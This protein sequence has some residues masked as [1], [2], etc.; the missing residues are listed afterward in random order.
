MFFYILLYNIF[1]IFF[2][3]WNCRNGCIYI[4]IYIHTHQVGFVHVLES[5][6]QKAL[7]WLQPF[8]QGSSHFLHIKKKKVQCDSKSHTLKK[9][10]QTETHNERAHKEE[11][12]C[13]RWG[14]TTVIEGVETTV[15]KELWKLTKQK[16]TALTEKMDYLQ[17]VL[18][19][20]QA[21]NIIWHPK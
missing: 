10:V 16:W 17:Q 12:H 18:W 4:Y 1:N 6:T 20:K 7:I 21:P 2:L 9:K 3:H 5:L 11:K 15:G 13:E 19:Q 14:Q 8:T